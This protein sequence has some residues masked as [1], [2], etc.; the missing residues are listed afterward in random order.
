MGTISIAKTLAILGKAEGTKPLLN[1]LKDEKKL[2]EY[3]LAASQQLSY[4]GS[5]APIKDLMKIYGK[6][7]KQY[8]IGNRD[9]KVQ[10]A[11]TITR[12]ITHNHRSFKG[13][14]KGVA[15]DLEET[16]KFVKETEES[17]K[18]K[19]ENVEKLTKE[20]DETKAKVK[21]L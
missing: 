4:L 20:I 6:K 12:L 7:L 8:D 14:N 21:A 9:L 5:T 13:F 10:Y 18:K 15:K 3:K 17:I 1:I 16:S 11:K 2:F 19:Q